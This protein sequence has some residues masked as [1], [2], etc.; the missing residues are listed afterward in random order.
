[1]YAAALALLKE[2][3]G[4]ATTAQLLTVMT[5]QQLRV[6]VQKGSNCLLMF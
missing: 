4:F 1:M 2:L 6:Q 5:R 3:G